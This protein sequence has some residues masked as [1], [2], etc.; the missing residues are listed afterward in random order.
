MW[1][2]SYWFLRGFSGI[3]FWLGRR[4]SP[5]GSVAIGTLIVGAALGADTNQ[6]LAYQIFAFALAALSLSFVAA[7]L[8][9]PRFHAERDLPRVVTAD[10]PFSYRVTVR[11]LGSR[12]ADGLSVIE[13][14]ADPRPGFEEFRSRLR[15]PS[16]R[17][18][19][20]LVMQAQPAQ[21]DETP[22]PPLAPGE[23]AEVWVSGFAWRRGTAVLEGISV[24]RAD[25]LGLFRAACRIDRPAR[26]VVL[27][28]RYSLPQ[29]SLGGSRR[30]QHGG[31]SLASSVGD[32]E[33]FIGLRDYRP[34][35]PLQRIHWK[36]FARVGNPVVR[37]YQD[38]FFERHALIL[39][40]FCGEAQSAEFEEA[41]SVAAS[42]A[43]TLDTQDCLLDL[44]FVGAEAY[45]FTAGRGQLQS[46]QLVE[47]LAG[48]RPCAHKPFK[49]LLDSIAAQ[50]S[51]LSGCIVILLA[52]DEHRRALL[53]RLRA[54][55]V[56][57]LA[58]AVLAAEPADKPAWLRVLRPGQV[59]EGLAAL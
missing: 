41:V 12:A 30:Y 57:L 3:W 25:P 10:Q 21:I 58:L 42:F 37:E 56:P 14:A 23:Q 39:D 29:V 49:T 22:L 7:R 43:C 20:R 47:I 8:L 31:V 48:V 11:N 26:L 45:C 1:R 16:Y 9:R 46:G 54:A 34:G 50:R 51:A 28:K 24:A 36:S 35:D 17:G 55:G 27:P 38:E 15:F 33:E 2:L 13:G 5:A 52:W 40:T 18:W 4:L 6:T 32:S 59:Q 53:D 19:W 44:V